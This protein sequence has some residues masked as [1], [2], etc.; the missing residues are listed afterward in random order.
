MHPWSSKDNIKQV[1]NIEQNISAAENKSNNPNKQTPLIKNTNQIKKALSGKLNPQLMPSANAVGNTLKNKSSAIINPSYLHAA[2]NG[3]N[4]A[5]GN[6]KNA[7][8]IETA[9][10]HLQPVAG[11][12][13]YQIIDNAT[14]HAGKFFAGDLLF[15]KTIL[16]YIATPGIAEKT[17][18]SGSNKFND[19]FSIN[20]SAGPDVSAVNF[21]NIGTLKLLYGAGM[22][23]SFAKNGR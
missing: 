14:M 3:R 17:K 13:V 6:E 19:L 11:G 9:K 7:D 12:L 18:P 23:Y 5:A 10:L 16:P 1:A 2:Y 4:V 20:F 15:N 8:I 22:G 21:S